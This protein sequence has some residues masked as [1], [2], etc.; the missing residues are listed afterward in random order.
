MPRRVLAGLLL[1]LA[2]VAPAQAAGD[3]ILL[4]AAASLQQ[5]LNR[6]ADG[7]TAAT[8]VAVIRSYGSSGGLARQ[9]ASGAPAHLY[10]SAS[11]QWADWLAS[12]PGDFVAARAVLAG[13]RLALIQPRDAPEALALGPGLPAALADGRLAIGDPL[14]VPAGIYARA[15]LRKLGLWESLRGRLALMPDV[16]GALAMVERG[17][18][19]A[20]IVYRSDALASRKVRVAEVAPAELHP[21]IRYVVMLL[22]AG[23]GSAV[24]AGARTFYDWLLS[25]AAGEILLAA[26]FTRPDTP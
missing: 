5:P 19:P 10:I 13:N 7:F 22:A 18:T 15:A 16:R 8:G 23:D 21:P 1:C 24:P 6:I 17:E 9:A 20:A 2:F 3:R 26:G 25:P 14:H 12:R 11:E 4:L